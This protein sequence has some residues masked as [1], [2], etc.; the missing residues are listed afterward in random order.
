M[1]SKIKQKNIENYDDHYW[2][3]AIDD[4][5]IPALIKVDRAKLR[6]YL[7]NWVTALIS[8]EKSRNRFVRFPKR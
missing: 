7:R 5:I 1:A 2:L 4:A 6:K 3:Q 8:Q